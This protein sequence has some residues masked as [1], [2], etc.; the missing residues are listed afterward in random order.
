MFA[1]QKGPQPEILENGHIL[2]WKFHQHIGSSCKA[3]DFERN[4][5][6]KRVYLSNALIF[7]RMKFNFRRDAMINTFSYTY[8]RYW[9]KSAPFNRYYTVSKFHFLFLGK[10]SIKESAAAE[11][12]FLNCL[13]CPTPP[14]V[15]QAYIKFMRVHATPRWSCNRPTDS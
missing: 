10:N 2:D 1:A 11:Y 9:K 15:V 5:I 4:Q 13:W 7:K 12:N 3:V 6:N 14:L 8:L